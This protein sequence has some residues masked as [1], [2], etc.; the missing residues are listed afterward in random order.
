MNHVIAGFIYYTF[1]YMSKHPIT[2]Q[3]ALSNPIQMHAATL[4]CFLRHCFQCVIAF[5]ASLLP[6]PSN[7][8][9]ATAPVPSCVRKQ[10]K[11]RGRPNPE[12]VSTGLE[13]LFL[14]AGSGSVQNIHRENQV[15]TLRCLWMCTFNH[16]FP[17]WLVWMVSL[18]WLRERVPCFMNA[19]A[20]HTYAWTNTHTYTHTYQRL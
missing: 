19:R 3:T 13:A 20:R 8:S 1:Y 18:L 6:L 9:L 17:C 7:A 14:R 10:V 16:P 15:K 4:Q 11:E 5:N 2:H 12:L